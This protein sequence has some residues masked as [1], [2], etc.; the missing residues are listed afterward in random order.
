MEKYKLIL[1]RESSFAGAAS[2]I[3]VS[4]N[5]M[6][7][8]KMSLGSRQAFDVD[9]KVTSIRFFMRSLGLTTLDQTVIVDPEGYREV[10][11]RYKMAVSLVTPVFSS[12]RNSIKYE[13]LP[14]E[15][16]DA[17]AGPVGDSMGSAQSVHNQQTTTRGNF[18]TQCGAKNTPDSNFC[19]NCGH[20]L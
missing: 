11:V 8:V 12:K 1:E 15:R 20:K 6:P 18:C 4:I 7:E 17:P 19:Y 3:S 5:G 13:I 16:R 2:N 9:Y 10:T 14:G